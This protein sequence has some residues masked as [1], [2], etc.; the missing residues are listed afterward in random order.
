MY[1]WAKSSLPLGSKNSPL[2]HRRSTPRPSGGWGAALLLRYLHSVRIVL[3]AAWFRI[4]GLPLTTDMTGIALAFF[5]EGFTHVSRLAIKFFVKDELTASPAVL[6]LIHAVHIVPWAIKPVYGFI[7]DSVHLFGYK[8]RSYLVVCA[9][10]A[11]SVWLTLAALPPRLGTTLA[12]IVIEATATAFANVVV[13][14][15]VVERQRG[16]SLSTTASLQS[17]AW[18]FKSL[19]AVMGA[20]ASGTLLRRGG[21]F[22]V[23]RVTAMVPLLAAGGAMLIPEGGNMVGEGNVVKEKKEREKVDVSSLV[24]LGGGLGD[25]D[26][27]FPLTHSPSSS[28]R[29]N[30]PPLPPPPPPPPPTNTS[31]SPDDM[32]SSPLAMMSFRQRWDIFR[33]AAMAPT[34]FYP[35][36]FLLLWQSTP[37]PES[38][39]FYFYT[40]GLGFDALFMGRVAVVAAVFNLIGILLYNKLLKEVPLRTMFLYA[41]LAGTTLALS[42]LLV[43]ERLNV[44]VGIPDK[45]FVLGDAAMLSVVHELGFMPLMVMASRVCPAGI[46]ATLFAALMSLSNCAR[47]LGSTAGATLTKLVRVTANDFRRLHILV[48]I[49]C[50]WN[51]VP[52]FALRLVPDFDRKRNPPGSKE[53]PVPG[54]RDI[55][56]EGIALTNVRSSGMGAGQRKGV[57]VSP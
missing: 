36:I 4:F 12:C 1:T 8:R 3:S 17:I 19:G 11:C 20:S 53:H 54:N 27:P 56:E 31:T 30:D 47:F 48:A 16:E 13:G 42:Q 25:G 43:T 40:S 46:E 18:S 39:M 2:P 55:T 34:I 44:R 5:C 33:R 26:L 28:D 14:S 24:G 23:F 41:C 35:S 38:A 51:L 57:P 52:L 10:A 22:A 29:K 50:G 21:A 6:D 9:V 32:V 37:N 49:C 45:V 15:L 7:S